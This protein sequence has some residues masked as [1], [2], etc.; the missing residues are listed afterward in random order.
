MTHCAALHAAGSPALPGAGGGDVHAVLNAFGI[1]PNA[2]LHLVQ[3]VME[4]PGET[5]PA[6][7]GVQLT[8]PTHAPPLH[9]QVEARPS[10]G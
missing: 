3:T 10:R 9:R 8:C 6:Q 1:L 7:H 4:P 2:V 5:K